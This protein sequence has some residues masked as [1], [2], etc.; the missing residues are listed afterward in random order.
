MRSNRMMVV[1]LALL[2]L[3]AVAAPAGDVRGIRQEIAAL[4]IDRAMN[5][6]QDQARALLPFL[7]GAATDADTR[8]SASRAQLVAAL[9]QARDELRAGGAVTDATRQALA[10]ARKDAWSGM[11]QQGQAL[12]QQVM[13]I[14]TPEQVQAL[15]QAHLGIGPAAG[16]AMNGKAHG[17]GRRLL[18]M[19]T[20]TSDAFLALLQARA[21]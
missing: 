19:R 15:R 1:T 12:R 10:A 2:P 8:L 5:L 20:L 3:S 14:L 7:Q 21:A 4:Q 13:Q 16:Q 6:S 18:F 9:A 17:A 11:R